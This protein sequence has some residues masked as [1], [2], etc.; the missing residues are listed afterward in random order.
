MYQNVVAPAL[1]REYPKVKSFCILE[2]N[3]RTG[4]TSNKGKDA[5]KKCKLNVFQIP[6]HSPDFNVM[7]YSLWAELERRM[8]R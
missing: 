2:D 5:K 6:K 1:K 8:R 3:D 4:N 7:D